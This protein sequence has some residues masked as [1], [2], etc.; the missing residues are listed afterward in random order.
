MILVPNASQPQRP[1]PSDPY[2]LMAAATMFKNGNL[3]EE[4]RRSQ[5]V[6][7]SEADALQEGAAPQRDVGPASYGGATRD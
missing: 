3:T 2:L 4:Q 1:K 6:P 5:P 7:Q